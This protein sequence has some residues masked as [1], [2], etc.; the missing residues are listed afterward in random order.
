M[1]MRSA[2]PSDRA[3]F[4]QHCC[5]FALPIAVTLG[6]IACTVESAPPD[7]GQNG[8]A[9]AGGSSNGTSGASGITAGSGGASLL[10][11]GGSGAGVG[12]GG[13]GGVPPAG[14]GAATAGS[15]GAPTAGTGGGGGG[16]DIPAT[17]PLKADPN[18]AQNKQINFTA[19]QLDPMAGSSTPDTNAGSQQH[20]FVDTNK[21]LQGKL[22]MTLGGIGTCCGQGGIG[23]FAIGLGFHEM[24]IAM[25]TTNSALPDMYKDA[26]PDDAEANRQMGDGRMEAW[27]GVD[28]VSWLNINEHDSFAYRAKLGI[29][30]LQEQDPGGDW[31]YF[32]DANGNVRWSDVYLVGYS[33]GSQTLAVVGK[34]VRIGRGIATSGPGNE[35]FPNATW[36]KQESATPLDRMYGLWGSSNLSNYPETATAAGWLGENIT[37]NGGATVADLMMGHKFILTGQGHSE[38]CAGDGGQWKALCQYAFGVM[39]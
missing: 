36:I 13:Q 34:Y 35:G 3:A 29:K 25:L 39:Q 11:G 15:A 31:E 9:G 32:L 1:G 27:D 33:Y 16:G 38:F 18:L 24:A 7:S 23:G 17:R 2:P 4:L 14:G 37:V 20:G 21:P 26:G 5:L 28:R 6:A 8:T 30:Y 19:K 22:A 10:P 12:V